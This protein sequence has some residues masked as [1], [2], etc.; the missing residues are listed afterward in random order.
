MA[1]KEYRNIKRFVEDLSKE[2]ADTMANGGGVVEVETVPSVEDA[3][4]FTIYKTKE[5]NPDTGQKFDVYWTK[6]WDP[7]SPEPQ[8]IMLDFYWE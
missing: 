7:K 2:V 6:G 3:Q 8:L 1:N 4:M 5:T